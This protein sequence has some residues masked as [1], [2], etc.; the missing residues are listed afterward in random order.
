MHIAQDPTGGVLNPFGDMFNY[1]PPPPPTTPNFPFIINRQNSREQ[2]D[3][4]AAI[5]GDG[6]MNVATGYYEIKTK[7]S[8]KK[9]D[10]V[11][12][13]YGRYTNLELLIHY[14]F[15]LPID[16]NAHDA[17]MMPLEYFPPSVVEQLNLGNEAECYVHADG[18]PSWMLAKALRLG[19]LSVG[20]RKRVGYKAL[21][22]EMVSEK[23]E[24]VGV[25]AMRGV[26]RKMLDNNGGGGLGMTTLK[27]DEELLLRDGGLK[28][29]MRVVVE[30]RVEQ[31]RILERCLERME[32]WRVVDG[33][34]RR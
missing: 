19:V 10:Q 34:G 12:L 6:G 31:K 22:G 30:W 29:T 24:E 14:G 20:E 3:D 25:R 5:G 7:K 15:V 26:C 16:I 8:Y 32:T 9:G 2:E 28:G 18:S 17:V 27:E 4:D 1:L 23:G 21:G 33:I 13:C 11:F